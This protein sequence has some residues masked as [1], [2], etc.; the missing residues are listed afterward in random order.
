MHT[1]ADIAA[2]R[3][4]RLRLRAQDGSMEQG[5]TEARWEH[6]PHG[7]DIGIRGI[8]RSKNEA[9][10][11]AALAMTQVITNAKQVAVREAVAIACQAPDDEIL[12]V[13]WLNALVYEMAT[14]HM[15]FSRFNVH[16]DD[17]RL[18]GTA[19]GE[20][21]DRQ[22]HQPAVE[23]KAATYTGLSV[24]LNPD[25]LWVAQCVVDV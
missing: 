18:D 23:V 3:L 20:H 9:F 6:F 21:I 4:D 14:R 5:H 19:F 2:F 10:E 22:R 13:D 24:G 7:A 12:L 16:V 8:G 15:V 11:Q 17:H 25:G 1:D